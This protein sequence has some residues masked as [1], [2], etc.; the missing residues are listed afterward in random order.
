MK[1]S[2]KIKWLVVIL[3]IVLAYKFIDRD[4][5]IG[6]LRTSLPP[7]ESSLLEGMIWGEKSGF[8]KIFYNDLKNSGLVHL[9]VVS[10]SNV[11]LLVGSVIE[12]LAPFL[13]RKKTIFFGLMLGWGYASLV[14]WQMPVVRAILMVSILYWGQLLGR[15]FNPVRGLILAMIIMIGGD[16]QAIKSISFWMSVV[17]FVGVLTAKKFGKGVLWETFWIGLLI[18]PITA[19]VFGKINLVGPVANFL[20]LMVAETVTVVGVLGMVINSKL[21]LWLCWPSLKYMAA[22]AETIGRWPIATM[23]VKINLLEVLGI[24]LVL[25]FFILKK[26]NA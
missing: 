4:T 23:A 14:G 9:V 15:K 5:M 19:M 22:V 20:A 17:A 2:E 24:Y 16:W 12:L 11:M 3:G 13:G 21:I 18:S 26:K 8:G 6:V 25:A 7:K 1:Y 10:G